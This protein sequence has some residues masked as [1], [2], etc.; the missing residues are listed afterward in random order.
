MICIGSRLTLARELTF[1]LQFTRMNIQ[2]LAT[3]NRYE[4][5]ENIEALDARLQSELTEEQRADLEYQFRVIYTL[6]AAS[7]GRAHFEFFRPESIKGKEIRNIVVQYKAGDDLYPHK[8]FQVC[9]LVSEKTGKLSFT[10]NN[11]AQAWRLYKARPP[12]RAKQPEN[13]NKEYCIYHAAHKDYTYSDSW[14]N[15]LIEAAS[16]DIKFAAIRAVK[17]GKN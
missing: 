15:F 5:P 9:K 6:D 10:N 14:V 11:H 13:T 7:K 16:D 4:I 17:L 2:Q 8:P 3:P 1:A 12:Y